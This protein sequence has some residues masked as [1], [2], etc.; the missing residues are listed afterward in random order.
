MSDKELAGASDPKIAPD[1]PDEPRE[2]MPLTFEKDLM[3]FRP[4]PETDFE[5]PA[6]KASSAPVSVAS[7]RSVTGLEDV[8]YDAEGSPVLENVERDINAGILPGSGQ[9]TSSVAS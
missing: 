7:P 2:I 6:P 4:V 9:Q 3:D 8:S 1:L 5:D